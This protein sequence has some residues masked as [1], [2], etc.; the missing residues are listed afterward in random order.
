VSSRG[1]APSEW[2]LLGCWIS[3]LVVQLE[4]ALVDKAAR[5]EQTALQFSFDAIGNVVAI[6]RVRQ[7]DHMSRHVK[8]R[9]RHRYRQYR[10][11]V[12]RNRT[13]V[14]LAL[15]LPAT[16]A[17]GCGDDRYSAVDTGAPPQG[18]AT[19]TALARTGVIEIGGES[20]TLLPM[21]RGSSKRHRAI[22][23]LPVS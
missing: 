9:D 7:R 12:T 3:Y 23:M 15:L 19:S 8:S 6:P 5:A 22:S 16:L 4:D 20:W 11:A 13:D 21:V 18:A 14:I 2:Q 17:T 1:T 10:L